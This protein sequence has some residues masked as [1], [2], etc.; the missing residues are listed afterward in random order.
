MHRNRSNN[1]QDAFDDRIEGRIHGVDADD[2]EVRHH[3]Q[4][5]DIR[6]VKDHT[7]DLVQQD[8]IALRNGVVIRLDLQIEPLVVPADVAHDEQHLQEREEQVH[9]LDR[10]DAEAPDQQQD[11]ADGCQDRCS[12]ADIGKDV[13]F[14]LRAHKD[15]VFSLNKIAQNTGCAAENDDRENHRRRERCF[16]KQAVNCRKYQHGGGIDV[17][18]TAVKLV[19]RRHDAVD[20]VFVVTGQRLVKRLIGRLAD[21]RLQQRQIGKYRRDG[22]QQ[23]VRLR[24]EVNQ[25][26]PRNDNADAH[27]DDLRQNAV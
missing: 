6:V 7:R 18:G 20:L 9:S 14:P 12:R 17:A 1:I 16:D 19:G 10:H 21:A 27:G 5:Q 3:R 23:A 25:H 2:L 15:S 8:I 11:L 4:Q 22:V 26:K 24:A 13:P